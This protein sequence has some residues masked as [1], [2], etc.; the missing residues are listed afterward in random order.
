MAKALTNARAWWRAFTTHLHNIM[1]AARVHLPK[2]PAARAVEV[3]GR[4]GRSLPPLVQRETAEC[5][6]FGFG[7]VLLHNRP[8]VQFDDALVNIDDLTIR[9]APKANVQIG[10]EFRENMRGAGICAAVDDALASA[11]R[12][13]QGCPW[14]DRWRATPANAARARSNRSGVARPRRRAS[15]PVS[16]RSDELTGVPKDMLGGRRGPRAAPR[17]RRRR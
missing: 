6:E 8:A 9:R 4:A 12:D 10:A 3:V 2:A 11:G 16:A 14:I 13:S 17:G 1:T 5:C 7:H 15:P